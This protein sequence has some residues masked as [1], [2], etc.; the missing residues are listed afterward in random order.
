MRSARRGLMIF[1]LLF[2]VDAP[3]SA[4]SNHAHPPGA[5]PGL[6]RERITVP[7]SPGGA[8]P[9]RLEA[10]VTR[11]AGE[12]RH[13]LM[14]WSHGA[15]RDPLDRPKTRPTGSAEA[16]FALSQRGWTVVSLIRRGYGESE[17]GY[18]EG[19]GFTCANP[20]YRAQA[21]ISGVDIL[22][23]VKVLSKRPDVDPGVLVLAGISAGGFAS[24]A[25]AAERP[26]GLAAVLNFAGGR[27]SNKP[28]SVCD[29]EQ[30]VEAF[31]ALGARIKVPTFWAYAAN[32]HYFGPEL[33]QRF[34]EA[35]TEAG[36]K[37]TF[38]ALPAFGEDGHRLTT[39][40][41]VALWRD[42]LDRFLRIHRLPTWVSPE[43]LATPFLP[44]P[45]GASANL[46]GELERYLRTLQ[47]EKAFAIGPRGAFA[48]RSG[49]ATAEEA[50]AESLNVCQRN[51]AECQIY[52]INNA[53]AR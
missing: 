25:A 18:V 20:N 12:G 42:P 17:G 16:V 37:A 39:R 5:P 21:R 6:H 33:A 36:G 7:I 28:D 24:L 38:A 30:L 31:G 9:F 29:E 10:M 8:G 40:E 50:I 19:A 49:K 23:A 43:R 26:P 13:P 46:Q 15:P 52:A 14:I 35:F 22:E 44:P 1:L 51:G 48:W 2:G 34:H 4:Q 47:F 45:P 53:L 11:P 3:A 41:G 32:D 27:G